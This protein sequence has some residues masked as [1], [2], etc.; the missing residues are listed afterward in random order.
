MVRANKD[1]S[2]RSVSVVLALLGTLALL[3]FVMAGVVGAREKSADPAQPT[4]AM[5]APAS[6]SP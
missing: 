4:A 5:S 2:F 6:L 3:S 1:D